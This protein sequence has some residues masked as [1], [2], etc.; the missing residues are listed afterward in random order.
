[1]T[2]EEV[3]QG[4]SRNMELKA[5]RPNKS[6]QYMKSVV[7]FANG[8]GGKIVFG[9]ED[10]TKKLL[11]VPED[12]VFQEMDAIANAISDSCEPVILP[13]IYLQTIEDKTVIVVE[14]SGGRQRP[15]YIKSMGRDHGTYVRIGGTSR[16]ADE[17]MILELLFE[18]NNRHFDQTV[19]I[20]QSLTEQEI[21][22]LCREMKAVAIKN[23]MS[24]EQK[25][26]V[27]DITLQQLLS[28]GVLTESDGE[29]KPTNAYEILTGRNGAAIQCGVFKGK[30]KAVFVDRR[31][32]EGPVW[33]QIEEAYSFVLRNIHLGARFSGVYRQDIYEIPPKAIREL[34]INAVVHRSYIEH[35]NIQVAVYDDRLEVFSPGKLA[36]GQTLERMKQGRSIIRNEALAH[37]FAYMNL[38]EHWGSGILRI[39]QEVDDMGL[40]EPEFEDGDTY[41]CVN[42]YRKSIYDSFE[43]A[44]IK[45]SD[46]NTMV[47]DSHADDDVTV[48]NSRSDGDATVIKSR[49]D[50]DTTVIKSHIDGDTTVINGHGDGVATVKLSETQLEILHSL[51]KDPKLSA[52]KLAE[53]IGITKRNVEK[54]MEKLKTMGLLL[55]YGSARYG[56]WEVKI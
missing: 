53:T 37:A 14:V 33:N 42:I 34:I 6:I 7:A 15:Y 49:S 24:E 19:C 48:I 20:S 32:Y 4:E 52:S 9:V 2:I 1:M 55:H 51:S 35:G 41:V 56:H 8:T 39:F 40:K 30:T 36:M 28:W 50:G 21:E 31:Q 11:G 27:K 10:K 3:L 22:S 44:A 29:L 5:I 54:N 47:R 38:S 43:A 45:N 17:N 26:V 18:G 46:G 16:Q 23:A 13:D 25:A 12:M